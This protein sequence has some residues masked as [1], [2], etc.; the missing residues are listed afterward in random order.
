MKKLII[1]L[2]SFVLGSITSYASTSMSNEKQTENVT[3][4]ETESVSI[5][6]VDV[7]ID[8]IGKITFINNNK[9]RVTIYYNAYAKTEY[10]RQMVGAG[11]VTLTKAGSS[12]STAT[13][14]AETG[15]KYYSI[16]VKVSVQN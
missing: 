4:V 14:Q 9:S 16:D 6:N 5:E 12:A 2:A 8:E 11:T 15:H 1:C 10:G 13:R 7:E 3:I